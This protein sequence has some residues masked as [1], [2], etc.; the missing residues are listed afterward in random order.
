MPAREKIKEAGRAIGER[1]GLR[2]VV[3]YG[4]VAKGAVKED[5]DIDIAVLGKKVLEFKEIIDII[6]EFTAALQIN[7]IDVE[8]LHHIDPLFRYQV[9]EDGI[10]LYG[11]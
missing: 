1:H 9:M 8:S 6:D 5:S 11:D 4:S 10:L 2:L 3:L 7:E